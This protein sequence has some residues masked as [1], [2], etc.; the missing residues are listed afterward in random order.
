M[1]NI[2]LALSHFHYLS[3]KQQLTGSL[4]LKTIALASYILRLVLNTDYNA[5]I[6]LNFKVS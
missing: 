6:V 3:D 2:V 5:F 1:Q 4:R